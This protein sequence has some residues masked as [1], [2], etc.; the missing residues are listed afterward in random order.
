[1]KNKKILKKF[2]GF[3][4]IEVDPIEIQSTYGD[5]RWGKSLYISHSLYPSCWYIPF[6][7]IWVSKNTLLTHSE[8]LD[9]IY[10][11]FYRVSKF[12][13]PTDHKL[14]VFL[15]SLLYFPKTIKIIGYNENPIKQ[16]YHDIYF[17]I[18]KRLGSFPMNITSIK[19]VKE[20]LNADFIINHKDE[21][22]ELE[23]CDAGLSSILWAMTKAMIQVNVGHEN[24]LPYVNGIILY[25]IEYLT[26]FPIISVFNDIRKYN[27]VV[28]ET[29]RKTSLDNVNN[30][31]SI[32]GF[33]YAQFNLSHFIFDF[34]QGIKVNPKIDESIKSIAISNKSF[35]VKKKVSAS[36]YSGLYGVLIDIDNSLKIDFDTFKITSKKIIE[37]LYSIKDKF[38][39]S[40]IHWVGYEE[41]FIIIDDFNNIT[42]LVTEVSTYL[43][44]L[45]KCQELTVSAGVILFNKD[46]KDIYT[47]FWCADKALGNAK[48]RGKNAIVLYNPTLKE[49]YH[50]LDF[51]GNLIKNRKGLEPSQYYVDPTFYESYGY[52]ESPNSMF[53]V[54]QISP[55]KELS[56]YLQERPEHNDLADMGFRGDFP[57]YQ[58]RYRNFWEP[59]TYFSDP[60]GPCDDRTYKYDQF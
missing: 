2:M 33:D 4:I 3:T 12:E 13:H 48:H 36:N 51:L 1:M 45:D 23:I 31:S 59:Y 5:T 49:T 24:I 28:I 7:E 57:Q 37:Y 26:R 15:D 47:G 41:Y 19:I 55:R 27:K 34:I 43:R 14:S 30:I 21:G 46:I 22:I 44:T 25:G 58:D 8:L 32:N 56:P 42:Q 11:F 16:Y 38:N 53:P 52:Y 60:G 40:E 6:N 35:C 9:E 54:D 10:E 39:L 50:T 17:E 29:L 18:F 20:H